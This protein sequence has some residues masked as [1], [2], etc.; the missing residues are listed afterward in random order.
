MRIGF[1]AA[2]LGA[3]T[4]Y[5]GIGQ[6][7]L[8]LLNHMVEADGS[9]EYLVYGPP[10]CARPAHLDARLR[11]KPLL[12]PRVG[13][14][15]ALASSV[16]TVPR[17]VE[18]DRLDLF[19]VPTVHPRPSLP[20]LPLRMPCPL[21]VTLH[22]LIPLT[23]YSSGPDR[24]PLR[25]RLYYRWNLRAA[26]KACLMITVSQAARR[27]II[28]ELG[29]DE[30]RVRVIYNGVDAPSM[31]Q[32]A[33]DTSQPYILCVGSFEARKNVLRLVRAYA[34]AI[35]S[36]VSQDLIIIADPGSG[37][38]VAVTDEIEASGL[39]DR[40]HFLHAVPEER[41]WELYRQAD[42]FVFPSLAEGFGLP[43][44]EAMAAGTPVITSDLPALREVLGDAAIFVDAYSDGDLAA[45][46]VQLAA[47]PARRM[48]LA[49]LGKV[50]AG[51]YTW[52]DCAEQTL[53]A[54]EE[55][56]RVRV[57]SN[58]EEPHRAE[59]EVA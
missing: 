46:M 20:A 54:Y 55:A 49:K 15:S 1:D 50:R 2:I 10:G 52:R 12:W 17:V 32:N 6:Y 34:R 24:M 57:P 5:S 16:W 27:E 35:R 41:L 38:T 37:D 44:L 45:A 18:A 26:A 22:D 48:Q 11:W 13:K 51:R 56:A 36:G 39:A 23:Y 14:L 30:K 59:A 47:S 3:S 58:G 28:D 29:L 31:A 42:L 43:P 40:V 7:S 9:N 19:H 25:W 21:V 8:K 53:T 33:P 4:R